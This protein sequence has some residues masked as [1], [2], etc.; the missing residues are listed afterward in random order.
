MSRLLTILLA[1]SLAANVFLGGFVAGRML[2]GPPHHGPHMARG[3]PGGGPRM[4]LFGA[5]DA[6]SPEGVK[7]MHETLK[8]ERAR[9]REGLGKSVELRRALGAAVGAETFDRAKAEAAFAA[10]Q[11]ADAEN[12]RVV[13]GLVLDAAEKMSPADRKAL[14]E[15]WSRP[16]KF[17]RRGGH[18]PGPAPGFGP[19]DGPPPPPE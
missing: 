4:P 2:G 1:M 9:V 7:I 18:G 6:L 5:M 8:D 10:I 16:R 11:A 19:E 17:K 3:E 14:A 15:A 12:H 13:V